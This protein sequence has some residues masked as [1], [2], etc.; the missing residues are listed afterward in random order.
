MRHEPERVGE[1]FLE[2]L[3]LLEQC[4]YDCITF[5][6]NRVRTDVPLA[7]ARERLRPRHGPAAAVVDIFDA[8]PAWYT[9]AV[10]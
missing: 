4:G 1:G 8:D 3:D 6:I 2:A 10:A 5:Y 7:A 9:S